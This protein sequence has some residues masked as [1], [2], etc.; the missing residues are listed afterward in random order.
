MLLDCET[1][2][3]FGNALI[4]DVA[5]HIVDKDGNILVTREYLIKNIR[6]GCLLNTQFYKSKACIYDNKIEQGEVDIIMWHDFEKIFIDDVK[7]FNV[8][9]F[10]AYNQNFDNK[11]LRSTHD[12]CNSQD[13][14]FIKTLDKLK[15]LC[16]WHCTIQQA[17]NDENFLNWAL[18]NEKVSPKGNLL[19]N[20]EVMYQYFMDEPN[21]TEEHTA[22]SDTYCELALLRR[23]LNQKGT[24]EYGVNGNWQMLQKIRKGEVE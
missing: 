7:Q 23:F 4:H 16:L 22:L 10:S 15:T 14:T 20:A 3:D 5:Y 2:G 1:V 19:S 11:A 8:Q 21:F 17:V 12:L 18:E 9:V 13:D 24:A 6:I